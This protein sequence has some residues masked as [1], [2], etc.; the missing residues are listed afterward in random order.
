VFVVNAATPRAR[1]S[2]EAAIALSQHGTVAPV[3]IHHRTNFAASMIDGR[4]V[5]E[6]PGNSRSTREIEHLWDYLG[7]RLA[8]LQPHVPAT[9]RPAPGPAIEAI[10]GSLAHKIGAAR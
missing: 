1:I 6:L 2:A 8:R 4:T 3:T 10:Q 9:A 5:M 7:D